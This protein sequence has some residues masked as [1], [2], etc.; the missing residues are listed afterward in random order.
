MKESDPPHI[1]IVDIAPFVE[2]S[3][4]TPAPHD[5]QEKAACAKKLIETLQRTGFAI[6][7]CSHIDPRVCVTG[8][9]TYHAPILML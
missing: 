7:E 9:I 5:E 2:G 6:V 3:K 8:K 4:E 1:A